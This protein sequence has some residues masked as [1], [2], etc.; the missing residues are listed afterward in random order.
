MLFDEYPPS[1]SYDGEHWTRIAWQPGG[2]PGKSRTLLFP[3]F[4]EDQMVIGNQ[5]PMSYENAERLIN[6]WKKHPHFQVHILGKSLGGRNLYRLTVTDPQSPYPPKDRW[7][8]HVANQHAGEGSSIWRMVGMIQWML[9]DEATEHRKRT[10]CHFT[11]QMSPDAPSHGWYRINADGVDMNR[12]Y[13]VSGANVKEQTHEAYVFQNDLEQLMQSDAPVTTSWSLH[14]WPG[15]MD[16]FILGIGPEIGK[17]VGPWEDLAALLAKYDS[18]PKKLSNPLRLW[19]NRDSTKWSRVCWDAGVFLQFGITN[20]LVEGAGDLFDKQQNLESGASLMKAVVEYYRG[21][22][23]PS[24]WGDAAGGAA[25]L[26]VWA[27]DP[28]VKVF[29]DDKPPEK[30]GYVAMRA[31]RNEYEP[32]QF[33]VRAAAATPRVRVECSALLH[34]NG[35]AAIGA[36]NLAWNFVGFIPVKRNTIQSEALW[37]RRAPCEIPDPLLEKRTIDLVA[38]TA[39]PVWLTVFV[40]KDAVPGLYRGEAAVLAGKR[41]AAIPIEL[42]VNPFVLPDERHLLVTNHFEVEDIA[43]AHKVKLGSE[44]FWAVLERY[45]RNMAAHRQNV[46]WTPCQLIEVARAADGKL[47]FHYARF[48]RFVELFQRAGAC[49]RIEIMAVFRTKQGWGSEVVSGVALSDGK[50]GNRLLLEAAADLQFFLA[51]LQDHLDQR[52]WLAKAMIHVCDEP[53]L[54]NLTSWR[55]ASALVQQA[56]PQL[57]RIEAIETIDFSGMLEVWVPKLNQF[58]RYRQAYELRRKDGEFWYYICAGPY[59]NIYPNRFLDFPLSQVRVLHWINYSERLTGYL[60][61][62]LTRG[63]G[64]QPFGTPPDSAPPGDTHVIYPGRDGPLNSIRWEMERESIED[65]EY[66]WLLE[67]KTAEWKKRLGSSAVWLDPRRRAEELCRRVVPAISACEKD[68]QRILAARQAIADEIA[69]LDQSPFCLI[70]TEPPEGTTLINGP[71]NSEVYGLVEPGATV[72]INGKPIMVSTD[73]TFACPVW[74][75]KF[76]VEIEHEGKQKTI[77]R[78]F[79]VRK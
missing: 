1:W 24:T 74:P 60:H 45:A 4:T 16:P 28:H 15:L 27:V 69:A 63:W 44:E 39:Q 2:E 59:G 79:S 42:T 77:S 75:N 23:E 56:A 6:E 51:D 14:G 47:S 68:V 7:V 34:E 55:N 40:P 48:D 73:H 70:Q 26:T 41:R 29:R 32:G 78:E 49:D 46:V 65:F 72:K 10:I 66:L 52:G 76:R 67:A 50:T 35:K 20:C 64:R 22:N 19:P 71:L 21:L 33:V 31:A 3:A 18:S 61:W 25:P 30:T 43:N 53:S 58:D 38:D 17:G 37:I 54:Q 62:G 13:Y 5:V 8:H 57:R 11:L 9:S 36:E 12:S